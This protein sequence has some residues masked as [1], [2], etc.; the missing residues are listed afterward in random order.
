[1]LCLTETV[2]TLQFRSEEGSHLTDTF[3]LSRPVYGRTAFR[4]EQSS[5]SRYLVFLTRAALFVFLKE[6]SYPE[7]HLTKR[8]VI[9]FA[10]KK[11]VDARV[12]ASQT[13]LTV[14]PLFQILSL[15]H[16]PLWYSNERQG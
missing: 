1:M 2:S 10:L 3:F 14:L 15:P 13:S 4:T 8:R 16:P 12:S 9:A 6:Y 11:D 5:S 7:E